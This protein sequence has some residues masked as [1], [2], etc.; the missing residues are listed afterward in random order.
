MQLEHYPEVKGYRVCLA[1]TLQT[2][3]LFMQSAHTMS[4]HQLSGTL[5]ILPIKTAPILPRPSCIG[6]Q[7]KNH[8]NS[9]G[10]LLTYEWCPL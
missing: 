8:I 3:T 7:A 4:A 1:Q 2:H 10:A 5:F 6:A 9:T